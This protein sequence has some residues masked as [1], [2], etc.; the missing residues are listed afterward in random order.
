MKF[1]MK[2]LVLIFMLTATLSVPPAYTAGAGEEYLPG[3]SDVYAAFEASG[4]EGVHPRLLADQSDFEYFRSQLGT[5]SL[6][7]D[8][9]SSIIKTADRYYDSAPSGY[10]IQDGLRL[11]AVSRKTLERVTAWSFAYQITGDERY[12]ERTWTELESVI[13]FPDWNPK[14][15]LDVAEMT[16]AVSLGYD[17]C[18]DYLSQTSARC[19]SIENA[20]INYGL[21]EGKKQYDGEGTGTIFVKQTMN[22]NSVCNGALTIGAL[23]VMEQN[24]SLASE[25]IS[26]A[27]SSVQYM[28]P[29]YAPDGGWKEGIGYGDYATSYLC[30]MSQ[31]LSDVLGTDFGITDCEGLDAYALQ[32][33]YGD[34]NCGLNNYHDE[35]QSRSIDSV[36]MWLG[37]R[38]DNPS[39]VEHYLY[40]MEKYNYDGDVWCCLN[41]D[42][43]SLPKGGDFPLDTV[44]QKAQMGTMRSDYGDPEGAYLAYHGGSNHVNHYHIDTGTFVLDMMGERWAADIGADNLTYLPSFTESRDTVY[45]VRAEGHNTLVID[46]DETSGQV[47]RSQCNIVKNESGTDTAFQ[48]LDMTEAYS[49]KAVSVKRGFMLTD[50]RR[51]AVIRDEIVLEEAKD[52]YWFMHTAADAQIISDTSALLT[53]DNKVLRAD[54]ICTGGSGELSIMEASPLPTSPNPDGQ[55]DN[56]RYRKLT[57]KV[58]DGTDI[59]IS[60]RLSPANEKFVLT[61]F[62]CDPIESWTLRDGDS[63][64]IPPSYRDYF[65]YHESFDDP[66]DKFTSASSLW[67]RAHEKAS[68]GAML[69]NRSTVLGGEYSFGGKAPDNGVLVIRT[70]NYLSGDSKN[71]PFINIDPTYPSKGTYTLEFQLYADSSDASCKIQLK[72]AVGGY[73]NIM[74]LTPDGKMNIKGSAEGWDAPRGKWHDIAITT[75]GDRGLSDIYL[76]GCLIYEGM[77]TAASIDTAKII[78]MYPSDASETGYNGVFAVDNIRA[79]TGEQEPYFM[80]S[81]SANGSVYLRLANISK[82]CGILGAYKGNTLVDFVTAA[83]GGEGRVVTTDCDRISLMRWNSIKSLIPAKKVIEGEIK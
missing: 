23:G 2:I 42:R 59:S 26:D 33:Y 65:V 61:A 29:E 80:V 31:A 81:D 30:R 15:F 37:N 50:N 32:R 79:Y 67:Q 21:I 71:D 27:L 3:A 77:T 13:S 41:Y 58:T 76:D 36:V 53:I 14:H 18:Y 56:S 5:G 74:E 24:P 73:M 63:S 68:V 43:H 7:D 40:I 49:H 12:A 66:I 82:T 57:F 20:I 52:V 17:W 75:H 39:V 83:E 28:L 9:I 8:W 4:M 25:I 11:L 48:V 60:V 46:P 10:V 64:Y 34:G 44:S 54:F 70:S 16:L 38:F 72:N 45:R 19:K 22:W 51:T 78:F 69:R 6:C 55:A 1:I 47:L 62:E 35:S